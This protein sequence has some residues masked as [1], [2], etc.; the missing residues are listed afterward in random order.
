MTECFSTYTLFLQPKLGKTRAL[1]EKPYWIQ[2]G[3]KI[4][5]IQEGELFGYAVDQSDDGMFFA[6]SAEK[7]NHGDTTPDV[8][9][10][11]VYKR[12]DGDAWFKMGDPIVGWDPSSNQ[13][14]AVKLSS[15]GKILAVG[16]DDTYDDA[17]HIQVYYW[18]FKTDTWKALGSEIKG[19]FAKDE[20]GWYFDLSED[21]K[22]IVAGSVGH[23]ATH[24][25]DGKTEV[26]QFNDGNWDLK[27]QPI[28]GYHNVTG[29]GNAYYGWSVAISASGDRILTSGLYDGI[30]EQGAVQVFDYDQSTD[31]W[32]QVGSTLFG[33]GEFDEFGQSV[34]M[35][36][37]GATI[38]VGAGCYYYCESTYSDY[39][40]LY[41]W[42]EI[43][44]DWAIIGELF[45]REG[46]ITFG[47]SVSLSEDGERVG[48][49]SVGKDYG[50]ARV[51]END[52]T[53]DWKQVG[54]DLVIEELK[55]FL[56]WGQ[57]ATLSGDGTHLVVGA[58][59]GGKISA[60]QVKAYEL[61]KASVLPYSDSENTY[62][63]AAGCIDSENKVRFKWPRGQATKYKNC[64]FVKKKQTTRCK[65]PGVA[66]M[67]PSTCGKCFENACND[68]VLAWKKGTVDCAWVAENPVERCATFGSKNVC[69]K[70]C[71][72]PMYDTLCY[73]KTE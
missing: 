25:A 50:Y 27:G 10:V 11:Q 24:N 23:N 67:C 17:G 49:V 21:G 20:L 70:T 63:V 64:K 58:P 30:V 2:V 14:N 34:A 65:I 53:M 42:D 16:S 44:D 28:I 6:A 22:T 12:V 15:N 13:G 3:Q 1:E 60:G 73:G 62:K 68:G 66:S 54:H 45:P 51:F 56:D 41:H 38:A 39:V 59:Q 8:G 31:N 9:R 33:D 71:Y 36:K 40:R 48:L 19:K 43:K 18:V 4:D 35:S 57:I 52:G 72:S 5:G 29:E 46:D 69:R 55:P 7:Y 61:T 47:N 37:S 26:Y 32:I